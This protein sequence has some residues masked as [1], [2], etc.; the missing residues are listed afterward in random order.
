MSVRELADVAQSEIAPKIFETFDIAIGHHWITPET[1]P[2]MGDFLI[3]GYE[4]AAP[5]VYAIE[6]P[7]DWAKGG[8]WKQIQLVQPSPDNAGGN[9]YKVYGIGTAI[10]DIAVANSEARKMAY[11]IAPT[12]MS[13]LESQRPMTL[14]QTITA[15]RTMIT[16]ESKLTPNHVGLPVK[17]EVVRH[18]NNHHQAAKQ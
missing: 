7:I 14:Q 6:F 1:T 12:E 9:E 17:I 13:L 3:A 4:K 15:A 18:Q 16:V 2:S 11:S 8:V 5:V 10:R